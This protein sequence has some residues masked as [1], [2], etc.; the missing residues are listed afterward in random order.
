[1]QHNDGKS[2]RI[3]IKRVNIASKNFEVRIIT[4]R[5][6]GAEPTEDNI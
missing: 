4:N 5:A 3:S 1:L 6:K 2:L